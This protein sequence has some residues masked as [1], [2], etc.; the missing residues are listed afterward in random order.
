MEQQTKVTKW[1]KEG[2]RLERY[3][4]GAANHWRIAILLVLDTHP[5]LSVDQI[6]EK[7]G[8]TF[9]NISQHTGRLVYAGLLNKRSVGS[10][11]V[12]ILSPYGKKFVRILK[13]F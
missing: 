7:L 2:K 13:T 3:T 9:K 10:S 4:K 8:G 12:H 6:A 11:V 5:E 1:A